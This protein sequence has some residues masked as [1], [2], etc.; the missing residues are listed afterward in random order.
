MRKKS[1]IIKEFL[2]MVAESSHQLEW[3][4][5]ERSKQEKLTQDLL[6]KLELGGYKDRNRVATQLAHCRQE[7]RY[8]KDIEEECEIVAEWAAS[9]AGA[10]SINLL[11]KSLG[12]MRKVEKYHAKRSYK[13]RVLK[14]EGE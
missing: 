3:A 10:L 7:R 2:D 13:P 5:E 8:Y 6:H 11:R 4:S 12:D 14:E 1:E 9:T